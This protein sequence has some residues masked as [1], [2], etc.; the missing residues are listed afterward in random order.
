[1]KKNF[2][3]EGQYSL[4]VNTILGFDTKSSCVSSLT[5][6]QQFVCIGQ[7]PGM[8]DYMMWPWI[9]RLPVIHKLYGNK[10]PFDDILKENALL[11]RRIRETCN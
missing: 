10:F 9:E 8:L 2:K 11:V 6:N 4:E 7:A 5:T 3:I 1:M